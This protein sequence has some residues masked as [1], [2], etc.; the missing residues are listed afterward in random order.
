MSAKTAIGLRV[1]T[2]NSYLNFHMSPLN[3]A[4]EVTCTDSVT[5]SMLV[6]K[7]D[8]PLVK[9][10]SPSV[11]RFLKTGLPILDAVF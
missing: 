7:L 5:L 1:T 4:F 3:N 2:W 11:S 6:V 9:A 10:Y 8:D